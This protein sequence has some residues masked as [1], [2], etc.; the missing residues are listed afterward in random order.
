MVGLFRNGMSAVFL[1]V[2]MFYMDWRLSFF[3]LVG[4]PIAVINLGQAADAASAAPPAAA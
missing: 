2:A 3:V 1:L 4:A